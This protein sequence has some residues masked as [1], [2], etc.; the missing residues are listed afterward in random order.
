MYR[1]V[2]YFFEIPIRDPPFEELSS[3]VIITPVIP[4]EELK[5]SN[6]V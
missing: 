1:S 2:L 5:A 3:L 4:I 6:C